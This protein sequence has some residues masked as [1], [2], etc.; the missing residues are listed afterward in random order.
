MARNFVVKTWYDNGYMGQ[1]GKH[2]ENLFAKYAKTLGWTRHPEC[3]SIAD[4]M[5][6][7]IDQV[8]VV[9]ETG[10]EIKVQI[11][12]TRHGTRGEEEILDSVC[13][14]TKNGQGYPGTIYGDYDYFIYRVGTTFFIYDRKGLLVLVLKLVDFTK[15]AK[16][17]ID[18]YKCR[19]QRK[20][21]KDEMTL[22]HFDDIVSAL[23]NKMEISKEDADEQTRFYH[24]MWDKWVAERDQNRR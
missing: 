6:K 20:G 8:Y 1:V 22:L 3:E 24:E 12:D 19:Y 2:C 5:H 9:D 10:Q 17:F 15:T 18:C 7:H 21:K 16:R 4:D 23:V 13:I 14:E 11:K